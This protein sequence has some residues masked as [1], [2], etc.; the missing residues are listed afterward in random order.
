MAVTISRRS[1]YCPNFATAPFG[2]IVCMGRI[3]DNID[4]QLGPH[5]QET[6][7]ESDRMDVAVGYFNLRGWSVFNEIVEQMAQS[8]AL[9]VARI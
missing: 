8:K 5:L 6:L 1:S 3:F 2:I 4:Q 9:P 7:R